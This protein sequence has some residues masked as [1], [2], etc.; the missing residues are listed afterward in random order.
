MA[1]IPQDNDQS[2]DFVNASAEEWSKPEVPKPASSKPKTKTDRWGAPVP[3][4]DINSGSRWGAP[5]MDTSDSPK[6]PD[7]FKK[8]EGKGLQWWVIVLII[9]IVLCLCSCGT[10]AVL[11]ATGVLSL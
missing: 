9:V 2:D 10:L 8:K 6:I 1:H 5:E 7:L 3:P 4:A 11:A